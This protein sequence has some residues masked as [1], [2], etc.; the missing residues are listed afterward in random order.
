MKEFDKIIGYG[1]IK[2]VL[3]Q[4][5]DVLK[6]TE[7]YSKL[8]VV[9]PNG[10]LLYGKPGLGKTMLAKCFIEA[11]GLKSYI[12]RKEKS[13]GDFVN[14][15][16]KTYDDA[17]KEGNVIILLDDMD[18]FSNEDA[19]HSNTEEYVTIQSCIDDSKGCGVFTIA[20]VNQIYVL[21]DSLMRRGRFDEIIEIDTPRGE[22]AEKIIEYFLKSKK[23]V[24]DIDVKELALILEGQS[25]AELETII[26]TAG[27]YAGYNNRSKIIQEDVIKAWLRSQLETTDLESCGNNISRIAIHEAGHVVISEILEPGSVTFATAYKDNYS[28]EGFTHSKRN[29]DYAE[30]KELKENDVI[31][32][33]GGKAAT[34]LIL[35]EDDQGC[36]S[37]L[38]RVYRIVSEFVDDTC[39]N[40]FNSFLRRESSQNTR[41]NKDRI[42]AYEINRYYK[43][44]KQILV[45]NRDFLE[46]VEK[47]LVKKKS[48]TRKDIERLKE[49]VEMDRKKQAMEEGI[50]LETD[51]KWRKALFPAF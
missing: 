36:N 33:L 12:I 4:Y 41:E 49:T 24:G 23:V 29:K 44:A 5:A 9:P 48:I 28:N 11:T 20:T 37:D 14:F 46:A 40:G 18:K 7:K 34:E 6:N 51:L 43:T 32:S 22:E 16:K 38:H 10:I 17:R 42:V 26:N 45:H 39:D 35:G 50:S 19:D 21:P 3:I 31:I 2:K 25:C 8:G 27:I 13:N 15:I 1:G 47:E 30:I